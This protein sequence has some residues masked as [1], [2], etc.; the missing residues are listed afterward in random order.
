[1]TKFRQLRSGEKV[2]IISGRSKGQEGVIDRVIKRYNQVVIKG[3]NIKVKH[4]KPS[5]G[6][7][8]R[9]ERR[10]FPIHRSNVERYKES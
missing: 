10:E 6:K 2:K 7:P 4:I 9:I 8:G 1:M 5:Q 3:I